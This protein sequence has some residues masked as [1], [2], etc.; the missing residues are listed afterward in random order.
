MLTFPGFDQLNTILCLGAHADDIEIG[1]G[2]TILKFLAERPGLKVVW[3]VFSASGPRR[4]E[5]KA[6]AQTFLAGT[7]RSK[8]V[9]KRFRDGF[10]PYQ[11]E[12]IKEFF[13][14]LKTMV[15][16]DLVFSHYRDDRHQD[17]R[18]L[19]DFTWN[20]FRNNL[21]LEYEIPKFDGD[22][23]QPNVFVPLET[24]ICEKKVT[25]ISRCF[26]TQKNK[27]WFTD[28]TFF[29]LMRLRG[30]ECG[31]NTKY[32][33]AF[34]GRKLVLG[35]SKGSPRIPRQAEAARLQVNGSHQPLDLPEPVQR[36]QRLK[37]LGP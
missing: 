34:Y 36:S 23:S 25:A 37:T 11:G 22:L 9:V 33:E 32:A 35:G 21:I 12:A 29:G 18:V 16:P 2:G 1:C 13:E 30:I 27:H 10:F 17:H 4:A 20:T 15:E 6:S 28:D 5:A 3:V 24:K 19:S 8:I 7:A 14:E 31:G 26:K